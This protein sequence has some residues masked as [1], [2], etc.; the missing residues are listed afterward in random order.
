MSES[1]ARVFTI[2]PSAPFLPT[3]AQAIADGRLIP[4]FPAK[5]DPLALA[6][7]TIFLPT[8]RAV[9]VFGEALLEA[10]GTDALILPRVLPL[11]DVDED[12][13][14]FEREGADLP[15]A[16]SPTA[17]RIVLARLV[18]QWADSSARDRREAPL[19]TAPVAA[20]ALAD[21]LAR[22]L[23]DLTIAGVPFEALD[24]IIPDH[25][26]EYWNVSRDFLKIVQRAWPG[27]LKERGLADP[28]AR[29]E[30]LLQ[31]EAERLREG[32]G[33]P[34]IAAGS[35]GSLPS[36]AHLLRIIAQRKDG[37]VV[38]PGLDQ[39]LD[40]QSFNGIGEAEAD[41]A[42]AHPQFGLQRLLQ[43]LG[44]KRADVVSLATPPMPARERLLS[45]AFVP[46]ETTDRW[47]KA[48]QD[49]LALEGL[50]IVEAADPREEALAI[51]VSLREALEQKL[52]RVALITPDRALAR[53]VAAELT[54]WGIAVD[55]SAGTPLSESESGRFARLV[56]ETAASEFAPLPLIAFLRHPRSRFAADPGVDVLEA[57]V[58]RGL[59]PARGVNGLVRAIETAR[60]ER[61]H[62]NEAKAKLSPEDWDRARALCEDLRVA[63]DPLCALSAARPLNEIVRAH[64][65]ALQGAGLDLDNPASA[66]A[67]KLAEILDEMASAPV[68]PFAFTL[69]DYADAFPQLIAGGTLRMPF[70]PGAAIRILG[71]IEARLVTFDRAVLGGLNEGTWPAG[72]RTDA[73][74][75]RPM[76]RDLHLNLPERRIGLS[77][78]DFVQLLG[79][80]EVVVT[81]ARRQSGAETVASRSWQ[82]LA[83]VAEESA[84]K[85]ALA[86]GDTLLAYARALD[87]PREA[88]LPIKPPAPKPPAAARPQRLAVTDVE[89]LVR[90][91]YTIYAKHVLKLF[92]LD[93]I[94]AD[95]GAAERG[96]VLHDALARFVHE[97]PGP[98]PKD[99]LARLLAGGEEAFAPYRSFPGAM[100]AWWPRFERVAGW[101]IGAEI[102]RRGAIERIQ[103]ERSGKISF[104]VDRFPFTLSAKADRIEILKNGAVA[105]LDYKTGA[106]PTLPEV[107]AGFSPQLPLEAAIARAG[108]F[109][110]IARGVRVEE[111][112][113]FQLSGGDPPGQFVPLHPSGAKGTTKKAVER[114]GIAD[115]NDLAD[116]A[117]K[118]LQRLI[119]HYASETTPYLSIPRPK[120]K[121]RYG[122][123]DHLA[124][125]KEWAESGGEE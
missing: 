54:R 93:E 109:P 44:I 39:I 107:I 67:E 69:R 62:P 111:I 33:G 118:G 36:V 18:Q 56:A 124:R 10:L 108:G 43:E 72:A 7:A 90:D 103:A 65:A 31:R 20:L 114:L 29:R 64:R 125:I 58:L 120:W 102:A 12:E 117:L 88:A 97:V 91:P 98:L 71:P 37:A 9:R 94:D 87:Q 86:R 3:L 104:E 59:R 23:D 73:F 84:W 70:D 115:C 11:G 21:E 112:G 50:T 96:N 30:L 8:R 24:K 113:V 47:G 53:R 14:A 110:D 49:P 17:R 79:T 32:A 25:L 22:V 2:P 51:A 89:H 74:L 4:G 78:H 40:E 105:V 99:S 92:P 80:R 122:N 15:D 63:L 28:T 77:A 66:D 61:H 82:R 26:D 123:Y 42:Q 101:F 46:A 83:A 121:R 85:T 57:G 38:L 75:N 5:G 35:T 95:P 81:R 68:G 41:S 27:I 100:A 1:P 16:I 34:V 48:A 19:V 116:F 76:R 119:A 45:E 52:S 55:D 6:D 13:I 106:R 60:I